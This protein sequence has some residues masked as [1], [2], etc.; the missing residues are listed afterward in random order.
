MARGIIYVM[1]TAVS[2]IVKIGK[3]GIN[4]FEKRMYFLEKNGYCNVTG[5]HREFAIEV[6]D[7]DEKEKL[8]DDIF[9]RSRVSNSELFAIDTDLAIQLLSSLDGKQIYP[10]IKT[11]EEIFDKA[12]KNRK[13]KA[14]IERIPDGTY[15]AKVQNK[16]YGNI[17]A[18]M[19]VENGTFIVEK[20]SQCLPIDQSKKKVPDIRLNAPIENN[21]LQADVP[22]NSPTAA[23][24]VVLGYSDD[25]WRRWENKKGEPL[26]IYRIRNKKK[27]NDSE[28]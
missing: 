7:Y 5:L 20:G 26:D 9:N 6:V 4:N 22:C 14:D 28:D 25:G 24:W 3:T 27:N 8:L 21:I 16:S 19:R 23:A 2:G 17:K 12:T 15:Y 11:K 10:T 18:T 1:S 13:I